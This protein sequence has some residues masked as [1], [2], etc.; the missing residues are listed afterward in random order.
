MEMIWVVN[1]MHAYRTRL[2]GIVTACG[3]DYGPSIGG[4]LTG[5]QAGHACEKCCMRAMHKGTYRYACG[6]SLRDM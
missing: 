3:H 1:C 2:R 6:A 5:M 4:M